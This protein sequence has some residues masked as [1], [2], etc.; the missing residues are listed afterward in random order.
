MKNMEK[1]G[2]F[3]SVLLISFTL[4]FV[5]QTGSPH[6]QN[7][8]TIPDNQT[9]SAHSTVP[10]TEIT[11]IPTTIENTISNPPSIITSITTTPQSTKALATPT[12]TP[13]SR[14]TIT[15]TFTRELI[16]IPSTTVYIPVGGKVIW[17]NMDPLNPHGIAPFD[18]NGAKY[19]G[20]RTGIQIPY[21]K[22]F[23]VTFDTVGSFEYM[24]TFQPATTG[25]IIVI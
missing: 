2:I 1:I 25:R 24:T 9:Y 3:F 5:I 21:N 6:S 14:P 18:T 22:T 17:K 15:I 10:I 4:F 12:P 13:T 19:F 20:G 23:E 16:I 7:I 8:P 11:L